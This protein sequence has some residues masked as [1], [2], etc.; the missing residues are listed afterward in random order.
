MATFQQEKK[1]CEQLEQDV[2][3]HLFAIRKY[4]QWCGSSRDE[5]KDVQLSTRTCGTDIRFCNS[6]CGS[7]GM[8]KHRTYTHA[9]LICLF[10][11]THYFYVRHIIELLKW[12]W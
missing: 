6:K 1:V 12:N 4:V 10:L 3:I 7:G 11:F 9:N 2:A 8:N 5:K